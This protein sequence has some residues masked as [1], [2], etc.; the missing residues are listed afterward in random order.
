MNEHSLSG[1]GAYIND[2]LDWYM[3]NKNTLNIMTY[4]E[5]RFSLCAKEKK[6]ILFIIFNRLS[7]KIS[8]DGKYLQDADDV[9]KALLKTL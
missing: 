2:F 5:D 1:S 8:N 3:K 6:E 9:V 4:V 7:K